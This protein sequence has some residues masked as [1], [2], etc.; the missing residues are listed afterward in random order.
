MGTRVVFLGVLFGGPQ[1]NVDGR[2]EVREIPTAQEAVAL[3]QVMIHLGYYI[4][5]REV[6]VL[7]QHFLTVHRV[8]P[9]AGDSAPSTPA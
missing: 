7:A 8:K 4:K 1:M 2:I 9:P 5:A 6:E 3:T